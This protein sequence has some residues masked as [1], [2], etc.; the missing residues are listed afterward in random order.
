[1]CQ[2]HGI[3]SIEAMARGY[4]GYKSIWDAAVGEEFEALADTETSLASVV[5][6][7]YLKLFTFPSLDNRSVAKA[8]VVAHELLDVDL[9][10]FQ[11]YF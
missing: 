1:M 6:L 11:E 2:G 5:T 3:F 8:K 9:S 4:H 7:N 10:L